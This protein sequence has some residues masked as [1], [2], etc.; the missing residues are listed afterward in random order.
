MTGAITAQY[1]IVFDD[2]FSTVSSTP[3]SLP[4]FNSPEWAQLFGDSVY[5]Y[6]L[7]HDPIA[8]FPT[9]DS[10]HPCL[11]LSMDTYNLHHQD[12]VEELEE[13]LALL[14]LY[15]YVQSCHSTTTILSRLAHFASFRQSSRDR[16]CY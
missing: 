6:P 10:Y 4:D 15:R 9:L 5:Q 1:H 7:D 14:N 12:A 13:D 8:H 11:S 3:E 16:G 2:W